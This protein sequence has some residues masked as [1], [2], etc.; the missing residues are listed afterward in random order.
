MADEQ[1]QTVNEKRILVILGVILLISIGGILFYANRIPGAVPPGST[2]PANATPSQ[3]PDGVATKDNSYHLDVQLS[4]GSAGSPTAVAL[5]LATG[6]PL[7]SEDIAHIIALLPPLPPDPAQQTAFNLPQ[8]SL[9]PPRTGETV[10]ET[11]PPLEAETGPGEVET[12]PLQV[13]RFAPQGDVPVAPF[14]SITFN[15][16]MVPLGTLG[17]LA[18]ADVP[19][20]I[21]PSLP[22]T[23][24]WLG[25]KT[26]TFESELGEARP[27]AHGN[28][29][30]AH[31]ASRNKI[32][33][34][35]S[36]GRAGHLDV[37]Y[38]RPKDHHQLPIEYTTAAGAA[39]LRDLRP[40]H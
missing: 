14:I 23:W 25:T 17:D 34:W 28:R 15:Q 18:L 5:P 3:A 29:I 8:E 30:P 2:P 27:P 1:K 21:E 9:P 13:L 10:K 4:D 38:A 7:A 35:R 11:F 16:P 20:Q 39:F 22:G 40:A 36:P 37:P 19:V 32:S 31:R 12:G 24:R 6:E 26:L 33:Q